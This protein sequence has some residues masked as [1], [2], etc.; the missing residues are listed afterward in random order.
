M[1]YT[2]N[3]IRIKGTDDYH[4]A[5]TLAYLAGFSKEIAIKQRSPG[6]HKGTER[7]III[8]H[9]DTIAK[10]PTQNP[11]ILVSRFLNDEY[12]IEFN[13]RVDGSLVGKIE[14][15]IKLAYSRIK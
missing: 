13:E 15:E 14:E 1:E 6:D 4:V 5:V 7:T 9:K 10:D 2:S 8:F 3:R 11:D 12:L